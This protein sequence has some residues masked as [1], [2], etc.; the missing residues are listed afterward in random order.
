[1]SSEYETLGF[2]PCDEIQNVFVME[3]TKIEL[4][5]RKQGCPQN[6]ALII[7]W[8]DGIRLML[9]QKAKFNIYEYIRKNPELK[10]RINEKK[11][12]EEKTKEQK[13]W[14]ERRSSRRQT[15]PDF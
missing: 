4:D 8:I 15:S 12:N 1:M 5:L 9:M 10:A 14:E 13:T 11:A 2:V 6:P 3:M 7:E